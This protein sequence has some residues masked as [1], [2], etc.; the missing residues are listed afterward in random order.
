MS[1]YDIDG[2][3]IGGNPIDGSEYIEPTEVTATLVPTVT[4]SDTRIS[5]GSAIAKSGENSY[6]FSF[7]DME[8]LGISALVSKFTTG[9]GYYGVYTY[10]QSTDTYTYTNGVITNYAPTIRDGYDGF[11][12]TMSSSFSLD[13]L[14]FYTAIPVVTKDGYKHSTQKGFRSIAHEA[15]PL[16]AAP[17]TGYM[18]FGGLEGNTVYIVDTNSLGISGIRQIWGQPAKEIS[19]GYYTDITATQHMYANIGKA[20]TYLETRPGQQLANLRALIQ[21][22]IY[23]WE[24]NDIEDLIQA[25][26]NISKQVLVHAGNFMDQMLFALAQGWSGCECDVRTTS[27]GVYVFS[28][29]ATYRNVTIASST[30]AD[31]VDAAPNIMTMDEMLQLLAK[32]KGDIMFHWQDVADGTARLKHIQKAHGYG[33]KYIMYSYVSNSNIGNIAIGEF[34]K[35]GVAYCAGLSDSLRDLTHPNAK[36]DIGSDLEWDATEL[37]SGTTLTYTNLTDGT[38]GEYNLILAYIHLPCLYQ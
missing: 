27:D 14:V 28:H 2:N 16:V 18:R 31:L 9:V 38:Y 6:L 13:D 17:A 5:G 26:T 22:G 29:D 25:R 20:P 23:I 33:V 4:L 35:T 37:N 19:N 1:I 34:W 11:F 15:L 32:F 8:E 21:R 7:A 36:Y 12:Y 30:Y 24:L 10:D 3:P